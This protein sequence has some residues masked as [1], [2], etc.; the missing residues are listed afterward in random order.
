[1]V[2]WNKKH[3]DLTG[4]SAEE[5][6]QMKL[7]DWYKGDEKSQATVEEG[8]QRTIQNGF[9]DAEADLQRKDGI[10]IPMYLTAS[11]LTIDGRTYFVGIG[12]DITERKRSEEE[13]NK[14]QNQLLQSQ[15]MESVGRLAGGVAHDFNNMLGVILG[16]AELAMEQVELA[17]PIY[18]DLLEIRKAAQRS[19]DLTRQ[20]LAFARK[21][22]ISPKVLDLNDTVSGMLKMLHRLIGE[23]IHLAWLPG[24]HLWPIKMDP[25]QIDQLLANLTV[26]A[27]DAIQ[28]VGKITIQT[29]NATIDETYA[30]SRP[31]CTPGDYVMLS[32]SDTGC[33]MDS[34]TRAHLFEPFFTT[35]NIGQGTGLGLATVYGIV[36]QNGGMI[37]VYTE[38]G[39]GSNFKICLPRTGSATEA[40]GAEAGQ[41]APLGTETVLLV[42]DEEQILNL[43]QRILQQ[44]GYTVLA[45]GLPEQALEL[46]QLHP[47][48]IHL[49]V[50]DVV[51][52]G[53]NGLE[54]WER[55][56]VTRPEMRCLFMSGYTADVIAHQGVLENDVEFLEKPFR[57]KAFAAKVRAVLDASPSAS[58]K[59][60][61]PGESAADTC[62]PIASPDA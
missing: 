40:A 55:V 42:E 1:L 37:D 11:P 25:S 59:G 12:I 19:A 18:D 56:S 5:L 43:G 15:K 22:T 33:G 50:T 17:S 36:K 38:P 10:K 46:A 20:L 62:G 45:A 16:H 23:D 13:K 9:G 48:P 49:L 29:S 54:L 21:Q 8:I 41:Q 4:Y 28:G 35:K 2:R 14:L 34:E 61:C 57:A 58:A 32:V 24:D 7:L 47:G 52:P 44:H 6:A 53:M 3:E 60:K 27:R 30:Q 39:R 26:N 51:M 31:D